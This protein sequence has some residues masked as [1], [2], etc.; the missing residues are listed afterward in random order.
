MR[1]THHIESSNFMLV[2]VVVN[3]NNN[4][5]MNNQ[6]GHIMNMVRGCAGFPRYSF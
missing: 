1:H 4:Y 2:V 3:N 5:I 6:T